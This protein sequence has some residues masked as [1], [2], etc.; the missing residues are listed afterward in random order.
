MEAVTVF[1]PN[2]HLN[3]HGF[4]EVGPDKFYSKLDAIQ[5][6]VK[7]Q[8]PVTWNYNNNIFGNL[9][10]TVEPSI[11]IRDLYKK[12]AKQLREKYDYVVIM[13]SGG[14]DST[15][16]LQ[17][18]LDNNIH[19]DEIMVVHWISGDNSDPQS[20]INAEVTNAAL[21]FLHKHAEKLSTTL[22]RID[23]IAPIMKKNIRDPEFRINSLREINNVHNLGIISYWHNLHVRHQEYVDCYN[24][25]KTVAFVWA[26][27]KPIIDYDPI[28]QKHQIVF[29]DHYGHAP[30]PRDQELND[31]NCNHEQFYSD[32]DHPLIKV[33]QAHLLL[34]T[35]K[36]ISHR[37]DI[38]FEDKEL[39]QI[40]IGKRGFRI[41]HP[42]V[43]LVKTW[44][45]QKNYYL[46]RN[47]LNCTIYP[48]WDFLTYHDDKQYYRL[49][50]PAYAWLMQAEPAA[51]K[52][53]YREFIKTYKN[54]PKEWIHWYSNPRHAPL[55]RVR[56][57][58]NLE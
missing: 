24:A 19:I 35:C 3:K 40:I 57:C 7:I 34:K 50:H 43:G 8:Q 22:V 42:R 14:S 32:P 30:Q 29:E 27:E 39:Q 11:D 10:W 2:S 33:K 20:F 12:R 16:M 17:T 1:H 49:D 21:P 13:F 54:L 48:D 38:F 45:Q 23:D 31:P 52:E 36:Q 9:D 55:K 51:C 6:S 18:F 26:E 47:A 37:S 53:W 15:C 5:H 4:F 56:I 41:A 58:Y 28:G 44:Y 46:D 25:G